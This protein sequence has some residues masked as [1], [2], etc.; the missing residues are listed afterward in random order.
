MARE[1]VTLVDHVDAVDFSRA[2]IQA[3]KHLPGGDHHYLHWQYAPVEEATYNPPY[4][5]I[6][7]G[8]SLHWM[9]WSIVLPLF[10]RLLSAGCFLALIENVF[11]PQPWWDELQPVLARYSMN[12]DF[13]GYD[14]RTL[15]A[16]LQER[17][18]FTQVGSKETVASSIR[19]SIEAYIESFHARNGFSRDRMGIET[20]NECDRRIKEIVTPHCPDGLMVQGLYSRVIW[21]IPGSELLHLDH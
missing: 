12:K 15:A 4:G 13:Q 2:A 10:G 3:G 17:E 18:L 11:N 16:E 7:A 5:L 9:D 19:Q 6:T 14:N 8:A 21:G 1:L 20:A